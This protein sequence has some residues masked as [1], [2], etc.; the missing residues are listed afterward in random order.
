M[1]HTCTPVPLPG[2][3]KYYVCSYDNS[4]LQCMVFCMYFN[5]NYFYP[6]R[7]LTSHPFAELDISFAAYY[8]YIVI[9][10]IITIKGYCS[11]IS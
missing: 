9:I 4:D 6:S 8:T 2:T 3:A 11:N 5:I 10:V 1:Q 7:Y